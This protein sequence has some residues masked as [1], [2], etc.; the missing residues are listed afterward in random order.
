MLP[1]NIYERISPKHEPTDCYFYLARQLAECMMR[2]DALNLEN[3]PVR[4]ERTAMK[5]ILT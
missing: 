5:N 3:Y 2:S 4:M 1:Y